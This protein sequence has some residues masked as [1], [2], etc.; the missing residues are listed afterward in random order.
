MTKRTCI[1]CGQRPAELPDRE[2]MGRPIKEPLQKPSASDR[3]IMCGRGRL[4]RMGWGR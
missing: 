2:R 3:E 4:G 1:I